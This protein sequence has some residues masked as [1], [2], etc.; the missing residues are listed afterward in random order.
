MSDDLLEELYLKKVWGNDETNPDGFTCVITSAGEEIAR[1][2]VP[3]GK[4][5]TTILTARRTFPFIEVW[6]DT[7]GHRERLPCIGVPTNLKEG[8]TLLLTSGGR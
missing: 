8:T 4:G 1:C 2:W 5:W 6:R 3:S 7:W